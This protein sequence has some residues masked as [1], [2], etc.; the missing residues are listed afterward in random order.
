MAILV[1]RLP[2]RIAWPIAI[3]AGVLAVWMERYFLNSTLF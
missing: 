1:A 2:A 3:V